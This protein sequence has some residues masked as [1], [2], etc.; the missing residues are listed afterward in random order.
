MKWCYFKLKLNANSKTYS[1][2]HISK[3]HKE[4]M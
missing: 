2:K 1:E 3:M 4:L